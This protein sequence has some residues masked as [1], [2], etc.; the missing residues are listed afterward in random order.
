[1][2][3]LLLDGARVFARGGDR[4]RLMLTLTPLSICGD[5]R[6]IPM[7]VD[8]D[9]GADERGMWVVVLGEIDGEV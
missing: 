7:D 9:I 8:V 4:L 1:M 6:V 2:M 3:G 5:M